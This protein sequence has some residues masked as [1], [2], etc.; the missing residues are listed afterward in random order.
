[1]GGARVFTPGRL[2][3]RTLLRGRCSRRRHRRRML[4]HA[5]KGLR[6]PKTTCVTLRIAKRADV[7]ASFTATV[8]PGRF[9]LRAFSH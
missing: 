5:C 1:M 3:Y 9:K 6:I 8:L 7:I 4:A 2:G